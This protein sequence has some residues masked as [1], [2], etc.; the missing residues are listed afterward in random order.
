MLILKTNL[1]LSRQLA[2]FPFLIVIKKNLEL[3]EAEHAVPV[4]VQLKTTANFQT[5]DHE[6][7]PTFTIKA[8]SSSS[9][10]FAE[11]FLISLAE[12]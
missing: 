11:S 4:Q 9:E 1:V 6:N 8:L 3:L 12:I 5:T 2:L 10:S 7:F